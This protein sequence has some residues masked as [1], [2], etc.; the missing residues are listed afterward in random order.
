MYGGRSGV[1]EVTEFFIND[2]NSFESEYI[3]KSF[4]SLRNQDSKLVGSFYLVSRVF[5]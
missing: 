1:A 2:T 4:V 5:D 3:S